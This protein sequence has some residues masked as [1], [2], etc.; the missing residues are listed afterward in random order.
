MKNT[1]SAT[2]YGTK[3][4]YVFREGSLA[5]LDS[6]PEDF[7]VKVVHDRG[8][9]SGA[10]AMHHGFDVPGGGETVRENAKVV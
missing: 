3:G 1:Q 4:S 8:R 9:V 2:L 10:S 5:A 6:R 7:G